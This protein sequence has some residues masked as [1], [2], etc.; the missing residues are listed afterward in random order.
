M[1]LASDRFELVRLPVYAV[2][3]VGRT[4]DSSGNA[5]TL[6]RSLAVPVVHSPTPVVVLVH[7][8]IAFISDIRSFVVP[9]RFET[10]GAAILVR[11]SS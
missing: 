9:R 7:T 8:I 3:T 5:V 4:R 1:D 10:L 6:A 11:P 2:D